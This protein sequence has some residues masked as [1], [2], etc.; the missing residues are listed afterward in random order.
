[1]NPILEIQTWLRVYER[2]INAVYLITPDGI[3]GPETA[4]TVSNFQTSHDLPVT[5]AV[6]YFTWS[7]LFHEYKR[8][9]KETSSPKCVCSFTLELYD[10]RMC[11]DDNFELVYVLQ[12]M[13]KTVSLIFDGAFDIAI[14]GIYDDATCEAVKIFQ[15]RCNMPMT[16]YVDKATWDKLTELYN[17][18]LIKLDK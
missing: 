18:H 3:Y 14:N 16:D 12:I 1:M 10:N 7:E 9:V 6:D 5:G 13:L 4:N 15:N 11:K 17:L 2:N 8:I